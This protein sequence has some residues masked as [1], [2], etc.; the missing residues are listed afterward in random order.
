MELNRALTSTFNESKRASK[1]SKESLGVYLRR[2]GN[3]QRCLW[4]SN[5]ITIIILKVRILNPLSLN[6]MKLTL[7]KGFDING[8]GKG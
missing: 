7:P 6:Q 3:N 2:S 1:L 5:T 8:V 4:R